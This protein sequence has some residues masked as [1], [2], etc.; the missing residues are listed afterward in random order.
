M[1]QF[2]IFRKAERLCAREQYTGM[3]LLYMAAHERAEVCMRGLV[4]ACDV[5]LVH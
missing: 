5:V 4:C 2:S 1:S 3:Q